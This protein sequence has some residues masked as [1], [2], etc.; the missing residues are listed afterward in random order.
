MGTLTADQVSANPYYQQYSVAANAA[1]AKYNIPSNVFSSL[2]MSESSFNPVAYNASGATG[3]AQFMPS[4][5]ANMGIDPNNPYQALDASAKYLSSNYN[6]YGNWQDA[7]SQYKGYSDLT[8]GHDVA[9]S[10][11]DNA[12]AFG[13]Q[14][15]DNVQTGSQA[16]AAVDATNTRQPESLPYQS[17]TILLWSSSDW[18]DFFKNSAYGF[19][20]GFVGVVFV[21]GSIWVLINKQG[22]KIPSLP[23][24]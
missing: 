16:I 4:T 18:K 6:K 23:A 13:G 21:I 11:L 2:I 19:M 17:K 3:I 12:S 8:A 14:S 10:V 24:R 15:I 22:G 1:A 20:I 9:N 5:A 7:I